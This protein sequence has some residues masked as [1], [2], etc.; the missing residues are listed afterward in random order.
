MGNV[1]IVSLA[2]V[3][4]AE[5]EWRLLYEM[6]NLLEAELF[7]RL[8]QFDDHSFTSLKVIQELVSTAKSIAKGQWKGIHIL[9]KLQSTGVARNQ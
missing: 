2:V 3:E 4:N 9:T 1:K 7:R 8:G 5:E 6:I